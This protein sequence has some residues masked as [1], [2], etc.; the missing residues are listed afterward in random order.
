V[1]S[2]AD[3]LMEPSSLLLPVNFEYSDRYT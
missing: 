3:R 2:F 1:V